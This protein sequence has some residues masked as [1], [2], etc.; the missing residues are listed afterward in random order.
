MI[1]TWH[2]CET[3]RIL[4][5]KIRHWCC[6]LLISKTFGI[7]ATTDSFRINIWSVASRWIVE[8]VC[9]SRRFSAQRQKSPGRVQVEQQ[10]EAERNI[11]ILLL[12]G[13]SFFRTLTLMSI[14]I[15]QTSLDIFVC[16]LFVC[17]SAFF[18][19]RYLYSF[20]FSRFAS[21][22]RNG[23][24]TPNRSRWS[25][26]VFSHELIGTFAFSHTAPP[27]NVRSSVYVWK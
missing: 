4:T 1:H 20:S 18:I 11:S 22:V 26:A 2:I 5:I 27:E 6:I 23:I 21:H 17:G 10:A 15:T 24:D 9:R 8:V 14:L 7:A 3:S 12:L 19:L 25:A 13:F 16:V